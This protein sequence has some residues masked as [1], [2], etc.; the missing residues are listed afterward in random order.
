LLQVAEKDGSARDWNQI[1]QALSDC[2]VEEDRRTQ[3]G[4]TRKVYRVRPEIA[5]ELAR[6]CVYVE[7]G[8][9]SKGGSK[10]RPLFEQMKQ[11]AAARKAAA[12][13]VRAGA[14]EERASRLATMF[15]GTVEK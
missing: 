4:G 15:I 1:R 14:G 8:K 9:S 6:Q 7:Q 13:L 10:R 11:D 12:P 3:N 2:V 5:T